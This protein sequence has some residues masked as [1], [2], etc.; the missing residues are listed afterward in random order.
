MIKHNFIFTF[1]VGILTKY[2][3]GY[4][5]KGLIFFAAVALFCTQMKAQSL[6]QAKKLYNDGQYAEAKPAFQKLVK[7][8]PGNASYNL[9][10]GVC[11]Y[12]TGDL[13]G[14]EKYL[15]VATKRRVIEAYKYLGEVYFQTYRF[16]DAV[17][18]YDDYI[19]LLTKKKRDTEEAEARQEVLEDA[20]RML[21]KVEAVQVID[22]LVVDKE[23][24]LSVYT[25]SEEMGTLDT[26]ENFFQQPGV[27]S[28]VYKNQKGDKIYYAKP[29]DE[30]SYC[31]FTQSKLMNNWAD[32]KQLPMNINSSSE[33]NFPFVMPDGVTIY[34]ASKGNKSL[35]GYDLFVTRYN[36][37]SDT[38]LN[39]EQ[40]AMPFN[41]P[42]NDYMIV[43]D[44]VKGLGWFVS[45]RFQPEGKVCVYLFIPNDDHLRVES[46][47]IETKRKY[48]ALFSIKDTWTESVD[49]SDLIRLSHQEIPF[50][51]E[52]VAKDFEFVIN[53]TRVYYTWNEIKSSQAKELYKK[54]V[55][56]K[57]E[58]SSAEKKLEEMRQEYSQK[59]GQRDRLS[60]LIKEA[61][62]RLE[63]LYGQP[64][65]LE[66]QARNAEINYLKTKK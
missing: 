54:S 35:G 14:A 10:Y 55:S 59:A 24:F 36:M 28:S 23:S 47:D 53:D 17:S 32:E 29:T 30:N 33:D 27:L 13:A 16:E 57:R 46:D 31:L 43:Y 37:N 3:M 38:Y 8:S 6:D 50:G 25:L 64:A 9:W 4:F 26:Y 5:F 49:Y 20:Q 15:S 21:E 44:E 61:E 42:Y 1:E 7:Q 39:P 48:A 63:Q 52:E 11:C 18:M 58:I 34:F 56:L 22:S 45:D 2:V 62:E 51:K 65:E 41:S 19:D 40:L 66:K 12:K 60:S